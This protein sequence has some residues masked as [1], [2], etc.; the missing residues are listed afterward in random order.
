MRYAEFKRAIH[1]ELRQRPQG[2]TWL[3]LQQR[4]NLPYDRP[5][6]TW[7]HMMEQEIGLSRKK[8]TSRAFVWRVPI[9]GK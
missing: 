5:C 3:E 6:P 7:T 2:L 4:L 9:P 1:R 8:G